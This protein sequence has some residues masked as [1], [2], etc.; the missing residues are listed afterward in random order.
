[1][2]CNFCG[3]VIPDT[4]AVC[5][6]CGESLV[7]ASA[8]PAAILTAAPAAQP[9]RTVNVTG[10][11]FRA[12]TADRF[13]WYLRKPF[14]HRMIGI[15]AGVIALAAGGGVLLSILNRPN[16]T[17]AI[18]VKANGFDSRGT[19]EYEVDQTLLTEELFGKKK[20]EDAT[21]LTEDEQVKLRNVYT[22][23]S[24]SITSE[25]ALS[26]RSNGD[27][28]TFTITGLAEIEKQTKMKFKSA[29]TL[30]F[31]VADLPAAKIVPLSDMIEV[32]FAGFDGAGCAVVTL[33]ADGAPFA[34]EGS[35][36]SIW[37]TENRRR[38]IELQPDGT[39][40]TLKNGD[41]FKVTAVTDPELDEFLLETY[42]CFL[43]TET[44]VEA[45]V[46]G[47]QSP[48]SVD[49]FS[50]FDISFTGLDGE[51]EMQLAWHDTEMTVGALKLRVDDLGD[52]AFSVVTDTAAP[53][54]AFGIA[55]ERGSEEE[56][57][58]G[59][60]YLQF[61]KTRDLRGGD[62][63]N[64]TLYDRWADAPAETDTNAM[65]GMLLEKTAAAYT[66]DPAS[67]SRY[68]TSDDQLSYER[69]MA[70]AESLKGDASAYLTENWSRIVHD[71]YDFTCYDQQI[72]S[73]PTPVTVYFAKTDQ[74][75]N[76][77]TVW[78]AY[79]CLCIDSEMD[80][81]EERIVLATVNQPII[82][83][84]AAPMLSTVRGVGFD[85]YRS[86]SDVESA[87]WFT[88]TEGIKLFRVEG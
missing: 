65:R 14:A 43:D 47:L 59:A 27:E 55:E 21:L 48:A 20:A 38:S 39:E 60:Y 25:D 4:A 81:A 84:G 85:G 45:T 35:G 22:L 80:L 32:S 73:G 66:V 88:N 50:L 36:T 58:V 62:T 7:P 72:A 52:T 9:V 82:S 1:M 31:E 69:L 8:A 56:T 71:S 16:L 54:N 79:S 13:V 64:V 24:R 33:K 41:T 30:T 11:V 37:P 61:D 10:N 53:R 67:L 57:E 46:S 44:P 34:Y 29:D 3:K 23:L 49:V 5:P 51:G 42:G 6:E 18:S 78:I 40:G 86:V 26:G 74:S 68:V 76:T 12:D 70:L 17:K 15:C 2:F 75:G 28:I 19:V 63:V 87:Y 77:Y 83:G